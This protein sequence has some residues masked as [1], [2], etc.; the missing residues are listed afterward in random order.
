M[1]DARKVIEADVAEYL[2]RGGTISQPGPRQ[3]RAMARYGRTRRY[4]R[5]MP[6]AMSAID[7]RGD[8]TPPRTE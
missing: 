6:P 3:L 8:K 7:S 1:S 4:W 2:A 5:E